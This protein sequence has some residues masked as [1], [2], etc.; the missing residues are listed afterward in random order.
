MMMTLTLR[1]IV[2]SEARAFINGGSSFI[3]V[4]MMMMMVN[5]IGDMVWIGIVFPD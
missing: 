4:L 2:H 5:R 3:R 1:M